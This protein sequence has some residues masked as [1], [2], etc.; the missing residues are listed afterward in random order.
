MGIFARDEIPTKY[1]L[2]CLTDA[3]DT[4]D[5]QKSEERAFIQTP[6]SLENVPESG[7]SEKLTAAGNLGKLGFCEHSE[8]EAKLPTVPRR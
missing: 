5:L 1:E 2:R 8:N 3:D 4:A 7:C 6:P